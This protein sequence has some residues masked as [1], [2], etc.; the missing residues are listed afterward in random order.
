MWKPESPDDLAKGPG[1][2]VRFLTV[3]G[4]VGNVRTTGLTEKEPVGMYYFPFAQNVGRGMTLV[5]RTAGDPS[6][7]VSSIR[8]QVRE[9]DP[10]LP[11]FSVRP[12]QQRLEES[13]VSRRT[14]MLLA[15]L[16]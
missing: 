8:Q 5:T 2:K 15:V 3:V 11:F 1:P 12:M 14:P 7:L 4:V 9:I 10:E 6:A 16:F 13:L